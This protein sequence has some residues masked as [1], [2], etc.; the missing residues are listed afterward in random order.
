VAGDWRRDAT[1]E[2]SE[3][4]RPRVESVRV[5]QHARLTAKMLAILEAKFDYSFKLVS[6]MGLGCHFRTNAREIVKRFL[7]HPA[8]VHLKY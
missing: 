2:A 5:I 1:G 6:A 3:K 7:F 4:I 8:G